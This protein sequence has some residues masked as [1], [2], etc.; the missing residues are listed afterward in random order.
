MKKSVYLQKIKNVGKLKEVFA[1]KKV[2]V[3]IALV[4]FLSYVNPKP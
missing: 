3:L 1:E 4:F 2:F